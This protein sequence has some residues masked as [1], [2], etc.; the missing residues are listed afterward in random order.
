MVAGECHEPLARCERLADLVN[1]DVGIAGVDEGALEPGIGEVAHE[2][3]RI[4]GSGVAAT[5]F[6]DGIDLLRDA[7]SELVEEGLRKPLDVALLTADLGFCGD[8]DARGEE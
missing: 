8:R 5:M 6:P 2:M 3:L 1:G 4:R 7:G